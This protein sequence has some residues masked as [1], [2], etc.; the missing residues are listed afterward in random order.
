MP[1]HRESRRMAHAPEQLFDLV[2]DVG[3]YPE[4]LPWV[5]A[6]RIRDRTPAGF[7]ADMVVGFRMLRE[8]FTS[9]VTL[10]RPRLVH[11]DYVTGPLKYLKNDWG[12]RPAP[13]GGTIVDFA[14]EF[15]FRN[16][17]FQKVAGA[18]FHEAFRSMVAAFERRACALYGAGVP[19]PPSVP[20]PA[21]GAAVAAAP[22]GISSDNATSAA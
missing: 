6:T 17:L 5:V 12:F 13:E 21:P 16:P 4:F 18:F 22:S 8:R 14:V 9:R 15:E 1:A 7:T 20:L 19:C 11:V 3:R 10:D 2:A